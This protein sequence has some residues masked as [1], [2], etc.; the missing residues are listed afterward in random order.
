LAVVRSTS[1]PATFRKRVPC[2]AENV[3][4]SPIVSYWFIPRMSAASLSIPIAA[5]GVDRASA[6]VLAA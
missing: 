5:S 6:S 1:L 2:G 4:P 3:E